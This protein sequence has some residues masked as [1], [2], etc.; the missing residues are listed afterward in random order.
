MPKEQINYPEPF[1]P[2]EPSS[3]GPSTDPAIHG[4]SWPEPTVHVSWLGAT[5]DHDGHAQ[6]AIKAPRAYLKMLVEEDGAQAADAG[7]GV[8]SPVLDRTALN[9]LIRVLR[10]ARDQAYGRDE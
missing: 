6:V 3:D 2:R 5:G 10:R 7:P 1:V 9:R 8:Y 4:E